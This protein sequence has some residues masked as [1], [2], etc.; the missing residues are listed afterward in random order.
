MTVY[1]HCVDAL[2]CFLAVY[3]KWI[4]IIIFWYKFWSRFDYGN[5]QRTKFFADL[6]NPSVSMYNSMK[7]CTFYNNFSL[8]LEKKATITKNRKL[9]LLS[10]GIASRATT[11]DVI[12]PHVHTHT[13]TRWSFD[14]NCTACPRLFT[15]SLFCGLL[16]YCTRRSFR[17]MAYS[18]SSFSRFCSCSVLELE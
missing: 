6:Y 10:V 16:T 17:Q 4:I 12:N 15:V 7:H 5:I 18:T 14:F 13:H 11:F 1:I 8:Q 2:R 3:E 9:V